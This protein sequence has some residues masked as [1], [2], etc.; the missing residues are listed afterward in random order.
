M[1][2]EGKDVNCSK[3][4][5]SERPKSD[6]ALC[7]LAQLPPITARLNKCGQTLPTPAAKLLQLS[8]PVCPSAQAI[9]FVLPCFC[10]GIW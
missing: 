6:L 4:L 2:R 9:R 10:K 3:V 5:M 1:A 8:L 7:I